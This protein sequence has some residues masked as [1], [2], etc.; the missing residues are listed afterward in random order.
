MKTIQLTLLRSTIMDAV[1]SETLITANADRAADDK[2][3]RLAYNEAAGD[4]DFHERKLQRCFI[5]AAEEL[6]TAMSDYVASN[7]QS[8]ADNAVLMD[9]SDN[10]AVKIRLFVSDRFNDAYADSI[11][12][13]G[14]DF[15]IN[16]MIMLW[17]DGINSNRAQTYL[18]NSERTLGNI[19]RCFNKMPPKPPVYPYTKNISVSTPI[20]NIV[21]NKPEVL[22]YS[23]DD[24]TI[25]DIETSSLNNACLRITDKQEGKVSFVG[26]APG[27]ATLQLFSRHDTSVKN[28][29][30]VNVKRN[31]ET[32]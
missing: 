23:I 13:L 30:I 5:T 2:A 15:I 21:C 12:R 20:V 4:D 16:K 28:L 25:D 14:S 27:I 1:K 7:H 24:G 10:A 8:S 18:A 22:S 9:F 29:V 11:A 31:E 32:D 3:S 6:K 26:I 19:L 17:W